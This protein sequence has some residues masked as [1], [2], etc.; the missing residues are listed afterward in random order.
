MR[1]DIGKIRTDTAT[2]ILSLSNCID[3]TC[4]NLEGKIN[5]H[6]GETEKR[7]DRI[8][9]EIRA[10][11]NLEMC[12]KQQAEATENEVKSL[13]EDQQQN[14]VEFNSQLLAEKNAR[15][16][17]NLKMQKEIDGLKEKLAMKTTGI[18]TNN[19][20]QI[21]NDVSAAS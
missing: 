14:Q 16:A 1:E 4:E 9:E 3:N 21:D 17:T 18:I 2:E 13:R 8:N 5:G 19:N 12:L 10:K 15:Q 11:K 7:L 20:K 6:I